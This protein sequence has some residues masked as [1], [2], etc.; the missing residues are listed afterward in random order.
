MSV[1]A[2]LTAAAVTHLGF[3]EEVGVGW[4]AKGFG[5]FW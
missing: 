2:G 5:T 4:G 1:W 3:I